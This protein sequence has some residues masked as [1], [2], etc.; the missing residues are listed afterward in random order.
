MDPTKPH[1]EER[2][3]E[4]LIRRGLADLARGV[5]SHES[6]LVAIG[7]PRLRRLGIPVPPASGL[8]DEPELRLYRRL[9]GERPRCA[10]S[11]YNALVRRL[12]SFERALEGERARERWRG[13]TEARLQEN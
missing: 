3:G 9:A 8:P 12:V 7:A 2:P 6:L 10:H 11:A 13:R 1:A 5:E 4:E